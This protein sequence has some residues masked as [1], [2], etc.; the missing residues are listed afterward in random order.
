MAQEFGPSSL[1]VDD[2]LIEGS[3]C[4]RM[5]LP[6]TQHPIRRPLLV[7]DVLIEGASRIPRLQLPFVASHQPSLTLSPERV[8]RDMG[9]LAQASLFLEGSD[10]SHVVCTQSYM[11]VA[12]ECATVAQRSGSGHL[13]DSGQ[14]PWSRGHSPEDAESAERTEEGQLGQSDNEVV[15][16][17][18][19][20]P[21]QDLDWMRKIFREITPRAEWDTPL[22]SPPAQNGQGEPGGPRPPEA[23][24]REPTTA[25]PKG[26]R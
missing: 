23:E 26:R 5:R 10:H 7:D 16:V 12:I 3:A 1:V 18:P 9:I 21:V 11:S 13:E 2:R 8:L 20:K 25:V 19:P 24:K 22:G 14:T 15:V 4:R 6:F 17:E